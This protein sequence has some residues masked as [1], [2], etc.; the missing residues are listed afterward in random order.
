M[1]ELLNVTAPDEAP[2][3][4][5]ESAAP[6]SAELT[7]VIE[8]ESDAPELARE[9]SGIP[10]APQE[11]T[12]VADA[13]EVT[14]KERVVTERTERVKR[15]KEE[16]V[17]ERVERERVVTA[18]EGG[19]ATERVT[20][21]RP[22]TEGAERVEPEAAAGE[23]ETE[24]L[25]TVEPEKKS[26]PTEAEKLSKKA[27]RAENS[28]KEYQFAVLRILLLLVVLWALFFKFIGLMRMPSDEMYPRI[29]AGDMV[30]YYRLDTDVRAQD[31]IVINKSTPDDEE[32]RIYVLRV[33]AARGD[34]VEIS[35]N[36]RLKINGSNMVETNIFYPT[37]RYEGFVDYPLTLGEDECFVLADSRNGG[38][39]SRYFGPVRRDEILGTVITILRRNNL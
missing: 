36:D 23:P 7:E 6:D 16:R 4:S 17:T 22:V 11:E 19:P 13:P 27:R 10:E 3:L 24:A 18:E 14:E 1:D 2:N 9:E 5:E 31:V 25:P 35:D 34:T 32:P 37:P 28:V 20:E 33:V 8:G 38:S 30:L 26:P 39:D 12:A 21:R 15:V 29:D